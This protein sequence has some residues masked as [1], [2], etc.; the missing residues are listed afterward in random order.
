LSLFNPLQEKVRFSQG[1]PSGVFPNFLAPPQIF[2]PNRLGASAQPEHHESLFT[3]ASPARLCCVSTSDR[4]FS[5]PSSRFFLSKTRLVPAAMLLRKELAVHHT[6]LSPESLLGP[7]VP[8][9]PS[10]RVSRNREGRDSPINPLAFHRF[11]RFVFPLSP[12]TPLFLFGISR[13]CPPFSNPSRFLTFYLPS[14]A[15]KG[16]V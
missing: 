16:L 7:I 5:L 12:N 9:I 11:F 10:C 1:S 13:V 14:P 2:P 15:Y 6:R 8:G 4:G 3:P